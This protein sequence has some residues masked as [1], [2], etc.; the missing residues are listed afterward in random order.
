MGF[1]DCVRRGIED[2]SMPRAKAERILEE[3]QSII[4]DLSDEM[5]PTM[6]DVEAARRVVNAAQAAAKERKRV[7]QLQAAANEAGATRLQNWTD[8]RGRE[9]PADGLQAFLS[10][11][12]GA[13]GQTVEGL[14]ESIRRSYRR[15]FTDA[16]RLFHANLIGMRRNKKVLNNVLRELFGENIPETPGPG[17]SRGSSPSRRRRHAPGS[18]RPAGTSA[19]SRS[20]RSRRRTTAARCAG[21]AARS[22]P[23]SSGSASIGTRWRSATITG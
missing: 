2:G 21:S 18:T 17:A 19:S 15:E 23:R 8:I 5:G 20:G 22:G 1:R 16:V 10:R 6:A 13:G 4:D 9:A 12:R 3:Y 11:R 7:M 14:T